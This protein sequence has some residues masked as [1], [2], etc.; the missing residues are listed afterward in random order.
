MGAYSGSLRLCLGPE[1]GEKGELEREMGNSTKEADA[2]VP[3]LYFT[4]KQGGRR[5]AVRH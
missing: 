3:E 5:N 4:K 1:K 2:G